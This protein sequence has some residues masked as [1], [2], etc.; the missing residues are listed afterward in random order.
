MSRRSESEEE[1]SGKGKR[2]RRY[3]VSST[4][5]FD[6]AERQLLKLLQK[7]IWIRA[8]LERKVWEITGVYPSSVG[9][10]LKKLR[11]ADRCKI[12]PIKG[13]NLH[14]AHLPNQQP[15]SDDTG[16]IR[17][18][19]RHLNDE[20]NH[21]DVLEVLT[22]LALFLVKKE[23]ES[24]FKFVVCPD[25]K[26]S[27]RQFDAYIQYRLTGIAVEVRNRLADTAGPEVERFLRKCEGIDARPMVVSTWM[28]KEAME[29]I[30]QHGGFFCNLCRI[31]TSPTYPG[32]HSDFAEEGYDKIMSFVDFKR[33]GWTDAREAKRWI[34]ERVTMGQID[35]IVKRA[36]DVLNSS[37]GTRFLLAKIR[38]IVTY[39]VLKM[40]A[41][42][43]LSFE[44]DISMLGYRPL[45]KKA[46]EQLDYIPGVYLNMLYHNTPRTASKIAKDLSRR[47][48]LKK[49]RTSFRQKFIEDIL[50]WLGSKGI[51]K[52]IN[53]RWFCSDVESPYITKRSIFAD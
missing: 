42:Q 6:E 45:S 35:Q 20:A 26:L 22:S 9:R 39:A 5:D 30:S 49:Q 18:I 16:R 7:K 12:G 25:Y 10:I 2:R 8:G 47:S 29:L 44:Q 34:N 19:E 53:S 43:V 52:R 13:S 24:S 14:I 3:T 17:R 15:T 51:I 31:F 46:K 21:A 50:K 23:L 32:I 11:G 4:V 1:N 36:R 28:T 40:H 27:G 41:K 48:Y 37:R 38:G 33:W